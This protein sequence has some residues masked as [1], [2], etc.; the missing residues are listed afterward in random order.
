MALQLL[1]TGRGFLPGREATVRV[2]NPDQT[3]TY[4]Q[5]DAD[6]SGELVVTLP[7]PTPHGTPRISATDSHP[8]PDDETGVRWT[9]TDTVTW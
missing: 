1:V 4:F 6:H 9:N 7:A 8:D 2:V 3:I 5:H